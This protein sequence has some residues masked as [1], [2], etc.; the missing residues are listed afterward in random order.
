MEPKAIACS[1]GRL[2][3]VFDGSR[4]FLDSWLP[5]GTVTAGRR[6]ECPD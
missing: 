1:L 3:I 2:A 5:A 6:S 4:E